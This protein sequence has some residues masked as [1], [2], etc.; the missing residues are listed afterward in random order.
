MVWPSL[1]ISHAGRWWKCDSTEFVEKKV[2]K[3]R[4]RN[5]V[6]KPPHKIP[7]W[8]LD[9]SFC[10]HPPRISQ[11][12]GKDLSLSLGTVQCR[13]KFVPTRLA[14]FAGLDHLPLFSQT[15]LLTSPNLGMNYHTGAGHKISAHILWSQM[16]KTLLNKQRFDVVTGTP[17]LSL[18]AICCFYSCTEYFPNL[19]IRCL[20]SPNLAQ[21]KK[22]K[23]KKWKLK[24]NI[25]V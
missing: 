2:G 6:A 18:P 10:F 17:V 13:R 21:N 15:G 11:R 14:F 16:R 24:S 25:I 23:Q 4:R 9:P 19:T 5:P 12:L 3:Q 7:T 8:W 20:A 22:W 1:L